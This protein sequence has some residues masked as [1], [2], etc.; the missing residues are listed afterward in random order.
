MKPKTKKILI[1][2]A[3]TLAIIG[4]AIELG[5]LAGQLI[6]DNII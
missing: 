4:A 2:T 5:I 3:I 6:L 1:I